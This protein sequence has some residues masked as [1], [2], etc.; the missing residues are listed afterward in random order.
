[1]KPLYRKHGWP[2]ED[3][4]GDAFLADQADSVVAKRAKDDAEDALRELRRCDALNAI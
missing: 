3:F 2:G 1:M 4:D